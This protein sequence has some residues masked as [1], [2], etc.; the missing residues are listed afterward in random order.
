MLFSQGA[1]AGLEI[2]LVEGLG[3]LVTALTLVEQGEVVDGA[4]RVGVLFPE[5]AF[6]GL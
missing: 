5:G 4:E 2:P 1:L 6:P 3:L